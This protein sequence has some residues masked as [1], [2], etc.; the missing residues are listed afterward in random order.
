MTQRQ[1]LVGNAVE[2][3]K[4]I[5]SYSDEPV[6]SV[7]SDCTWFVKRK[8]ACED[9]CRVNKFN[10]QIVSGGRCVHFMKETGPNAEAS[11]T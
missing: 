1:L 11:K 6:H 7:C 3:I 2:E 4:S 9:E 8:S 10:I 5:M